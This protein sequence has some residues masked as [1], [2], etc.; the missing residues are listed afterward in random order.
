L[1]VEPADLPFRKLDA[2]RSFDVLAYCPVCHTTEIQ[3]VNTYVSHLNL[4]AGS[5]PDGFHISVIPTVQ[6]LLDSRKY[7]RAGPWQCVLCLRCGN[8]HKFDIAFLPTRGSPGPRSI[9]TVIVAG[10][11]RAIAFSRPRDNARRREGKPALPTRP[12]R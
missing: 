2:D 10:R 9:A 6:N 11:R 3:I 5:D 4:I 12:I 7:N 1:D 8:D